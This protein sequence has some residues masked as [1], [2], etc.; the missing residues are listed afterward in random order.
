VV[1]EEFSI[2]FKGS[3][4]WVIDL[5]LFNCCSAPLFMLSGNVASKASGKEQYCSVI[6]QVASKSF[7]QTSEYNCAFED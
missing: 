2:S 4:S 6:S 1:V 7:Q 3:G 5:C